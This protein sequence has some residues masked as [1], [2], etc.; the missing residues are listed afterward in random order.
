M[1][2]CIPQ[3]MGHFPVNLC[4]ALLCAL[5]LLQQV[6]NPGNKILL[7]YVGIGF[8]Q[9]ASGHVSG[10]ACL[11]AVCVPTVSASFVRKRETHTHTHTE[12]ERERERDRERKKRATSRVTVSL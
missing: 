3:D 6:S 11:L 2:L 5:P 4:Q 7:L 1:F 9:G 10:M 12:R 8:L